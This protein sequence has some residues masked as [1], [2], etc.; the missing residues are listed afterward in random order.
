MI[1][2]LKGMKDRF[3]DDV[4]KYDYIIDSAK[5]VFSK[6]GFEKIITP[7]VEATE[8]FERGVGEETDVVSKEM[9]NF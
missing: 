2:I 7:V 5:N 8:L 9:N 4:K 1:Q 3:S 6:Y